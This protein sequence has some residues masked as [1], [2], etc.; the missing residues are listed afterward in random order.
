MWF[1][2]PQLAGLGQSEMARRYAVRSIEEAKAYLA[3]PVLGTRYI[4]VVQALQDLSNTN[5]EAVFG[6][7]DASKLRSSLTLFALA[8]GDR[9]IPAALARWFGD[10]DPATLALLGQN[11]I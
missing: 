11:T 6:S 8:G 5:A 10:P 9:V 7:V 3:H 4:E 1:I 2:F